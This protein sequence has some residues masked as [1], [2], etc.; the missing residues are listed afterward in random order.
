[1][2]FGESMKKAKFFI[3]LLYILILISGSLYGIGEKTLSMGG[4]S[5]WA[6]AEVKN[7]VIEV[8]SIRPNPVLMLSSIDNTAAQSL[9][10]SISFNEGDTGLFKDRVGHYKVI[11]SPEL[12]AVDSR[13][14]RIGTGAAL[15]G[16]APLGTT[17]PKNGGPLVIEPKSRSALFSPG[18]H[19]RDFSMEFWLYPLNMEN[20]EQILSWFSSKSVTGAA[21]AA[22]SAGG[23]HFQRII[24]TAVKNRLQWS[25]VDFFLSPDGSSG[26]NIG[27]SGDSPITPKTWSH[28]L[29]R[30]DAD[31]GMLEYLVN[32]ETEDIVYATLSGRENSEVYSPIP[33]G[34]GIFVLGGRY[35]GIID[36]FNIHKTFISRSSMRKY[37][38]SGGRAETRAID[39][40][41]GNGGILKIEAKGGRAS[42]RET[43]VNSEFRENGRFRFSDDSEMNFFFRASDNPYY[44]GGAWESFTPGGDI[45]GRIRGRYIQLAVDFYPSSDGETSPYLE[46]ISVVYMPG[47]PPLPPYSLTV[48]AA[49]GG[50]QLRWKNSP[51]TN[52]AGYLIYYG[53]VRGEYFGGEAFLGPSPI[54]AGKRNS[55]F[56]DG[57]KNGVLYYFRIAAY[58]RERLEG[59][60]SR[61][62]TARPLSGL[63]LLTA[64]IIE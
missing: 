47:E 61:E 51:D 25:F 50:V 26:I 53:D 55:L 31:T 7:N 23:N 40:G 45:S 59:E 22:L 12:E 58:N 16:A 32:G 56:I 15:F 46:E 8:P 54:D 63:S 35:M 43:A 28:H 20:G 13:F 52:T 14:A 9:D 11:A 18:A 36:E 10:L 41:T 57:L 64:G 34:G 33:G 2:R 30:F 48:I 3:S 27:L 1:M 17:V 21:D 19:I 44:W 37:A 4:A 39:L 6:T 42:I 62:V 38:P 60:F 5:A 24:C 49:D 29:I